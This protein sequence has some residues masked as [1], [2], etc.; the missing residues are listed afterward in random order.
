MYLITH[1]QP[2]PKRGV[3]FKTKIKRELL[4]F[5]YTG[6]SRFLFSF[7]R[8]VSPP[9]T[10]LMSSSIVRGSIGSSTFFTMMIKSLICFAS[11]VSIC[12]NKQNNLSLQVVFEKLYFAV[13]INTAKTTCNWKGCL[14]VDFYF[15]K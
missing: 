3:I 9:V 12:F 13:Y 4:P 6:R 5:V 7:V 8:I 10:L 15:G 11:F 14:E 1:P 2:P